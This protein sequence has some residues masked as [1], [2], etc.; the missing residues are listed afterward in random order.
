MRVCTVGDVRFFHRALVWKVVLDVWETHRTWR[1]PE[2]ACCLDDQESARSGEVRGV[3]IPVADQLGLK[4]HEGR[5][6]IADD[7]MRV[8]I[9]KR[10]QRDERGEHYR[11]VRQLDLSRG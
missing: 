4:T 6:G 9:L 5:L 8:P 7:G 2:R 11:P 1:R 10:R 3:S